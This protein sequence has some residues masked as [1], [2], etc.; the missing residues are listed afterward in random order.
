MLCKQNIIFLVLKSKDK[1]TI[2][3]RD[4]ENDFIKIDF[5]NDF[6]LFMRNDYC[7]RINGTL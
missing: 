7:R 2:L 3:M 1:P 4:F 6:M 5:E